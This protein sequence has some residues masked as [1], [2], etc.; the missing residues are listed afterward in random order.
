[1]N[2]S[3][4]VGVHCRTLYPLRVHRGDGQ[5]PLILC[6]TTCTCVSLAVISTSGHHGVRELEELKL[7][8]YSGSAFRQSRLCAVFS[9]VISCLLE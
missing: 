2:F 5:C 9:K 3:A 4:C 1:M 7:Q 8:F 6:K